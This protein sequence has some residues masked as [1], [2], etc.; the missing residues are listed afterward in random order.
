MMCSLTKKGFNL[1]LM[2]YIIRVRNDIWSRDKINVDRENRGDMSKRE[3]NYCF[4]P[5]LSITRMRY[6]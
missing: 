5:V 1:M 3:R 2:N 4:K 6:F